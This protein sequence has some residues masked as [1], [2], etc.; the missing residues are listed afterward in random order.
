MEELVRGHARGSQRGRKREE[1]AKIREGLSK[2]KRARVGKMG[3]GE[4]RRDGPVA[5][6]S[7]C[8]M[9]ESK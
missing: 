2:T 7:F 5:K 9:G 8:Q 3:D 4:Q 1:R 6:S